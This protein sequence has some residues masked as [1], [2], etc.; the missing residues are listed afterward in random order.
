MGLLDWALLGALMLIALAMSARI[1]RRGVSTLD[2]NRQHWLENMAAGDR[3]LEEDR[4][5][6]SAS[7]HMLVMKAAMEDLLRLDGFPESFGVRYS[8]K[9]VE[10]DTPQGTWTVELI[11][12][13]R[14]LRSSG[15]VLHGKSRWRLTGPG[16]EE[17][18]ADIASL[19]RRLDEALHQKSV[20]ADVPAHLARRMSHLPQ[21][22]H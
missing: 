1:M 6:M 15:R 2:E 3:K 19:M 22:P 9:K 5:N 12:R 21:E 7:E 20:R 10:L 17:E 14:G 4:K 11:M 18:Y 8:G 13:E 16:A